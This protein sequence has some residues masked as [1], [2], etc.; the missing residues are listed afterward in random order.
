MSGIQIFVEELKNV[1]F[2][3]GQPT[4]HNPGLLLQ[5][6]PATATGSVTEALVLA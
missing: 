5:V 6:Q 3:S 1:M 4:L 2:M